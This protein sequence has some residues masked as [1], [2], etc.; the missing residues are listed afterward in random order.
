MKSM[1]MGSKKS[2]GSDKIKLVENV[3]L[4]DETLKIDQIYL[5]GNSMAANEAGT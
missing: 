3:M 1:P 5:Q 2:K 4:N